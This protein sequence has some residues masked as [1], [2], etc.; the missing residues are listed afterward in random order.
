MSGWTVALRDEGP[1]CYPA[2]GSPSRIDRA[3]VN[4][5]ARE[6]LQGAELRWDLGIATHAGLQ[7]DF[8]AGQPEPAF[9]R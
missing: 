6:W 1:T 5:R 7:M 8:L 2:S 4:R 3:L 9:T